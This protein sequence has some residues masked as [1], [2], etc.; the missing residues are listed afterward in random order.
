MIYLC[1]LVIHDDVDQPHLHMDMRAEHH[2]LHQHLQLKRDIRN[3]QS[4]VH[5]ALF[6]VQRQWMEHYR[7]LHQRYVPVLGRAAQRRPMGHKA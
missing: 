7:E 2:R 4:A 6:R 3:V 1:D 5:G